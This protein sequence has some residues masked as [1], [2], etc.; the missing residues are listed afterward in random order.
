M[1]WED[2]KEVFL[3]FLKTFMPMMIG[4]AL[5][6]YGM[7]HAPT[8]ISTP[9]V[10]FFAFFSAVGLPLSMWIMKTERD[11]AYKK[12]EEERQARIKRIELEAK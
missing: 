12:Q 9:L 1:D 10:I 5:L 7:K 8:Y 3:M 6:F 2:H 4:G 11:E